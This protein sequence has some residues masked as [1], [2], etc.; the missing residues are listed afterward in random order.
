MTWISVMSLSVKSNWSF[1]APVEG[2]LFRVAHSTGPGG[3]YWGRRGLIAQARFSSSGDDPELI[4]ISRVYAKPEKDLFILVS[5]FPSG[6]RRIAFRGTRFS[7]PWDVSIHV[8]PD[9]LP[10]DLNLTFLVNS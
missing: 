3:V 10:P 6:E 1:S 9:Y 5:P 7:I 4:D 8:D 2:S